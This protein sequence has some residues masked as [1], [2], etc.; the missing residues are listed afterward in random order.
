MQKTM[1]AVAVVC[2]VAMPFVFAI[3]GE[4]AV[5]TQHGADDGLHAHHGQAE[6]ET[7]EAEATAAATQAMESAEHGGGGEPG[8]PA[9]ALSA[10]LRDLLRQE[11]VSLDRA[12]GT[13]G[14]D[15]AQGRWESASKTAAQMRDSFIL[16]QALTQ[17]QAHELHAKLPQ[18]FIDQDVRFHN[19]ADKLAD[20]AHRRDPELSVFYY[21]QMMNSCVQ[22]HTTHAPNRF[23]GFRLD[24]PAGHGHE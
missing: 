23:P 6:A 20:A 16:K 14:S 1:I 10:N 18:A 13:L 24:E 15:I 5:H 9:E 19:Q 2:A 3:A 7:R 22:C 12:M 8:G 21:A 11:M 17:E 4:E